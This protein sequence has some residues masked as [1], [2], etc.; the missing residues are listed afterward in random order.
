MATN[1][2]E[3]P[4]TTTTNMA[5]CT[6]DYTQLTSDQPCSFAIRS[7]VCNGTIGDVNIIVTV[8]VPTVTGMHNGT[9]LNSN[10][11]QAMILM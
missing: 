3:C 10:I 7:A 5:T 2:G 8:D 6:G 4:S 11:I 9:Q 1:C